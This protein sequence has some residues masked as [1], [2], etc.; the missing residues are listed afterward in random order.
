MRKI[1]RNEYFCFSSQISPSEDF[2]YVGQS[3]EDDLYS[4]CSLTFFLF[5]FFPVLTRERRESAFDHRDG[6]CVALKN[7]SEHFLH[8]L[9]PYW[10]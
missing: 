7:L 4:H 9:L 8:H 6:S 10:E 1:S 3:C 5:F 2:L